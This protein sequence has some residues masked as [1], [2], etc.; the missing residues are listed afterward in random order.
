MGAPL[1]VLRGEHVRV[2]ELGEDRALGVA[3]GLAR[4]DSAVDHVGDRRVQLG[5]D[6]GALVVRHGAQRRVDVA[7][8]QRGHHETPLVRLLMEVRRASR[9]SSSA[10]STSLPAALVR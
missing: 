1:R 10:A 6:L 5:A 4:S 3:L 2:T 7:I 9:S 8:G